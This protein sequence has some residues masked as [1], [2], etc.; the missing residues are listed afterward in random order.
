VPLPAAE[1]AS[2]R[3][4]PVTVAL[5]GARVGSQLGGDVVLGLQTGATNLVVE[6]GG[7]LASVTEPGDRVE[8][9]GSAGA[10]D[11]ITT[12]V[13]SAGGGDRSILIL[14]DDAGLGTG[15]VSGVVTTGQTDTEVLAVPLATLRPQLDGTMVVRVHDDAGAREVPVIVGM[16]GGDLCEVTPQSGATLEA[17][18]EVEVA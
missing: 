16:R 9:H 8:I 15:T 13:V 12:T 11:S 17:G 4:D 5:H 7:A 14:P 6:D 1:I 2:T 3:G 18:D 10:Q